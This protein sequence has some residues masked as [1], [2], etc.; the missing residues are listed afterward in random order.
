MR[1]H[2]RCHCGN[3]SFALDWIPE[4][5]QIPARACTCT[6]CTRHGAVWTSCP[7]GSLRIRIGEP[8]A[9]A[10]YRFGTRTADFHL[11]TRCGVAPVVTSRVDGRLCAVVNVRTF[12]HVSPSLVTTSPSSVDGEIEDARL[13]RRA[14]NWIGDVAFVDA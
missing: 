2:G 7:G 4:P 9:T 3:I 1:I 8:S 12:E 5:A 14:R 13:A 10:A 11:C 6:F